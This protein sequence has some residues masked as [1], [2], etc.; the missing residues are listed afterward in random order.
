VLRDAAWRR[1]LRSVAP[2]LHPVAGLATIALAAYA[3]SLGLG[4]RRASRRAVIAR[5]RH[6][7]LGPWV[8]ALVLANWAGGLA[9]VWAVRPGIAPAASGHFAVGTG[10]A[11]LFT[12][13]ALLSRRVPFDPRAR[14]IHPLLG[15]AALVLGGV[16]VFLGLQLLP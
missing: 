13:A 4:S 3:A 8:Y 5:A 10:I 14:A 2:Y 12:A 7:A 16:Q 9:S 1:M 6:R 15:A 11:A